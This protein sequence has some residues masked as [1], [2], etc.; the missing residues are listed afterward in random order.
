MKL[1]FNLYI[2]RV[3]TFFNKEQDTAFGF[4]K[5]TNFLALIFGLIL[6]LIGYIILDFLDLKSTFKAYYLNDYYNKK[7]IILIPAI[8]YAFSFS[9]IFKKK[10]VRLYKKNKENH[11]NKN[12]TLAI[13]TLIVL[14]IPLTI[15]GIALLI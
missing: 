4:E 9:P 14:T 11:I 7:T 8:I 12:I 3:V 2:T 5:A 13:D 6:V 1:L 15:L 10:I